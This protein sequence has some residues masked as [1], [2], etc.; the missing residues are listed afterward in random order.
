MSYVVAVGDAKTYRHLV[1]LKKMYSFILL[2]LLPLPG[3][4]HILKNMQSV[5][6]KVYWDGEL[7]NVAAA[8]QRSH[9]LTLLKSTS[10][11]KRT[12]R[13]L[14]QSFEAFYVHQL[15]Q[16]LA[17]DYALTTLNAVQTAVDQCWQSAG[18]TLELVHLEHLVFY[19]KG[20]YDKFF[21]HRQEAMQRDEMFQLWDKYIHKDMM[22]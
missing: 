7:R 9:T 10:N 20:L 6:M 19:I 5:I 4:W 13:F 15:E 21:I 8:I 1:Y 17:S 14:L 3:D 16:F 11:F 12:H 22:N 2:C 18:Q